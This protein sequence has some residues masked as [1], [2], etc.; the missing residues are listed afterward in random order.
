MC[1]S[2]TK[3]GWTPLHFAA[4]NGY[5]NLLD[6]LIRKKSAVVD[7]M[8]MKKQTPLHFAATNGQVQVFYEESFISLFPTIPF[9][10][11][12]THMN[13]IFNT[14]LKTNLRLVKCAYF[15][16]LHK[17]LIPTHI[18]P[19]ACRVLLEHGASLDTA[20][21]KSQKAIHLAAYAD[22]VSYILPLIQISK[23][24]HL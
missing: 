12:S 23:S 7:S 22:Q 4:K 5:D 13:S 6:Y 3:A 18:T 10:L 16:Q 24:F 15:F 14:D 8:T 20:D 21:D 17:K 9:H 11:H 2:K 1:H 19:Q